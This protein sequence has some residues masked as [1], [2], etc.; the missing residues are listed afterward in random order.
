VLEC[1]SIGYFSHYSNTP[2]LQGCSFYGFKFELYIQLVLII[3]V[4]YFGKKRKV[5]Y[6]VIQKIG[7]AAWIKQK[8]QPPLFQEKFW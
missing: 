4:L 8:N 1:W 3:V 6:H 7:G 5:T 2:S